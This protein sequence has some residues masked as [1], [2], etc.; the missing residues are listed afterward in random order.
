MKDTPLYIAIGLTEIPL[1]ARAAREEDLS[2]ATAPFA[3]RHVYNV[4]AHQS[5]T[6]L[7]CYILAELLIDD[8]LSTDMSASRQRVAS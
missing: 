8:E 3:T 5:E 2:T 4:G 6:A 1:A 7:N